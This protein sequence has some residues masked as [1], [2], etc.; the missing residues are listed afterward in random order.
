[1][2]YIRRPPHTTRLRPYSLDAWERRSG[3]AGARL[4]RSG[5][6]LRR[7]ALRLL[8]QSLLLQR[9]VTPQLFRTESVETW[10]ERK[11]T[12]RRQSRAA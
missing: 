2:L 6:G 11:E 4:A 8:C 3:N 12:D 1:M 7:L 10:R 5:D 9:C